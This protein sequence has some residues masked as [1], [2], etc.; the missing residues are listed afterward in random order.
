MR[1]L[2]RGRRIQSRMIHKHAEAGD[3]V[4]QGDPG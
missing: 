4:A 3:A 1:V 2:D